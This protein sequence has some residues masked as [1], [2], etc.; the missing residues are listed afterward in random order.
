MGAQES[1]ATTRFRHP[2][3]PRALT[4]LLGIAGREPLWAVLDGAQDERISSWVR[5]GS[6]PWACLYAGELAPELQEV[7]PYLVRILADRP[8]SLRLLENGWE[9]NWGVFAVTSAA[10]AELRRHLRRHL[11]VRTEAG[12]TLL[13]RWYDPRV[14]RLY[15]PTCNARELKEFFGPVHAFVGERPEAGGVQLFTAPAGK[16]VVASVAL[17][18]AARGAAQSSV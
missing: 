15:L 13:L 11:R 5:G 3:A 9:R 2:D 12:K 10:Q 18:A 14:L 4:T 6:C 16:L 17:A 8:E 1:R 7:A